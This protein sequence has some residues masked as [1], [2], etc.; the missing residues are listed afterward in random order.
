MVKMEQALLTE[1]SKDLE[2]PRGK[3]LDASIN[4]FLEKELRD[5]S[6]E[7]L[8][9]KEQFNIKKPEELKKLIEAG[10]IAEHPAWEQLIYWENLNKRI[11]VIN[12]WMQKLHTSS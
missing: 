5:A 12:H 9:I 10:K 8:N 1:L 6:A 2:I 11:K 4:V 7:I 3:I